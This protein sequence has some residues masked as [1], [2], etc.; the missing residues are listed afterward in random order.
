MARPAALRG[1]MR[2]ARA[3]VFGVAAVG[4]AAAAHVAAG[5]MVPSLPV[6]GLL[7]VAVAWVSVALAGRHRGPVTIGLTLLAVQGGLHEAFMVLSDMGCVRAGTAPMAMAGMP[8]MPSAPVLTCA[9][10]HGAGAPTGAVAAMTL[11][12]LAATVLTALVL[13]R[14]ERLVLSLL[15][16]LRHL[17]RLVRGPV[18]AVLEVGASPGRV[19]AWLWVPS[20]C[21][22]MGDVRRRGPPSVALSTVLA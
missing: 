19:R 1:P 4:L 8:G 9:S 7:S 18:V 22:R 2:A 12:H 17:V 20:A 11:A 13:A 6:L 5:G 10:G 15:G 21:L 14:S 3:G 16:L